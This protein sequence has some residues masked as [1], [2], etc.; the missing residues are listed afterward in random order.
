V[1]TTEAEQGKRLSEPLIKQITGNDRMTARFLYGE[2][3]YI[4]IPYPTT[5][6]K[7]IKTILSKNLPNIPFPVYY[8]PMGRP[9]APDGIRARKRSYDGYIEIH[10]EEYPGHWIATPERD[11]KKALAYAKRNREQ[12]INRKTH[13]LAFYCAGFFDPE[14]PWASR[15]LK[16]GRRYTA[17]YLRTRQG[18][19]DNYIVPAFGSVQPGAITRRAIDNWLMD[20]K[21][22]SGNNLA[23]ATKNKIMYVLSLIFEELRD[24][25]VV[26]INP[27]AGIK[28]FSNTPVKAR[29]A[30]P[31]ESLEKLY[32]ATHEALA[33]VWGSSMWAAMMLVFNDTGCRPGE[34]R[35]LTWADIDVQKRFIPIR[36]GIE[37]GTVDKIKGT[38]TGAVKA[39]FLSERTIQELEI[40]RAESSR[41]G[42]A[43]YVFTDNGKTPVTDIAVIKA[44]RRGLVAAGIDNKDWTP[45]WLR[46][47]FGTYALETLDEAEI[48]TL[49]GNGVT[50]L[51]K[52]YLHPDD[53]TLY[54]SAAGVQK[55]LD[56]A[57]EG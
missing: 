33:R 45:Y 34:V 27:V 44:F 22:L 19:V 4:V 29:G 41:T 30:I 36:R 38:K 16:K 26:E 35:A 1:T 5:N 50:V 2:T 53:E 48:S 9:K 55:K 3:G 49:M 37:S 40:W 20:L 11:R 51:R 15:M 52:H 42:D 8:T 10:L 28:P 47:S 17:K 21:G 12:L 24:M 7:Y 39:A 13:D 43:D 54:R 32:P 46:H 31:R 25:Q 23:G 14:S 56:K 6:Y 18:F 57:R